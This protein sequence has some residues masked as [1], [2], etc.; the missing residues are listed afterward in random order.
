MTEYNVDFITNQIEV[1]EGATPERATIHIPLM[2][3]GANLKNVFWT[4]DVLRE[5]TPMFK[6]AVFKYDVNGTQGSSH[7]P[8]QLFSPFY[9]VGW[10]YND[11]T[12]SYFDGQTLHV[13][14]DV[15]NPEVI[16]KMA[17]KTTDGTK[18]LNFGSMGVLLNYSKCHC[19]ICQAKPFG[20]CKHI[21]G[22]I[23]DGQKCNIVPETGGGVSKALHVA[24]TNNPADTEA[25]ISDLLL[26]EA[27]KIISE[28]K[29]MEK[30]EI[31]SN[32]EEPDKVEVA[33]V[34][35]VLETAEDKKE[36]SKGSKKI[37]VCPKC[38]HKFSSETADMPI[39]EKPPMQGEKP[40]IPNNLPK[41]GA[42]DQTSKPIRANMKKQ[43]KMESADMYEN[44]Y[45]N[46][47]VSSVQ[48]ECKRLGRNEMEFADMDVSQLEVTERI[49]S[50]IPSQ[51]KGQSFE[52]A[53]FGYGAPASQESVP[54]F[55]DMSASDRADELGDYNKWVAIFSPEKLE[56][57][58]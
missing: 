35:K 28:E 56:E 38:G 13:K 51:K 16:A 26:Q 30:N 49:L 2:H 14:G 11:E 53:D 27:N 10:T 20:S 45:K 54:S 39:G 5:I 32:V 29:I 22:Q 19:S 44:K 50:G 52:G 43:G 33:E 31:V 21:R 40:L 55:A 23:Y 1:A 41:V 17:R 34:Q 15:T 6:G 4:E 8:E 9:D 46:R 58:R 18:E 25:R 7:V 48:S 57:M 24:L 36:D 47:L 3:V 42:D 37:I 12:G